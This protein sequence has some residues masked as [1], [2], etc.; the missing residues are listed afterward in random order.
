MFNPNDIGTYLQ[1][2]RYKSWLRVLAIGFCILTAGILVFG[3]MLAH[4]QIDLA[5]APMFT[6]LNPPATNLMILLDDSGS[7]T[8]ES[9]G[10]GAKDGKYLDFHDYAYDN[11]CRDM[12]GATP[13][14]H[15]YD[16]GQYT[17]TRGRPPALENPVGRI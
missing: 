2:F 3:A 5:D 10:P 16:R 4:G 8:F 15:E 6:K 14:C 11:P 7:M 12:F 1:R 17:E 9:L 13:G